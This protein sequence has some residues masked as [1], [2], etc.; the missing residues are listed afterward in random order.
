MTAANLGLSQVTFTAHGIDSLVRVLT[1]SA[2]CSRDFGFKSCATDRTLL[3]GCGDLPHY[4]QE[5]SIKS[6]LYHAISIP[7]LVF[8]N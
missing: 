5:N 3:G 7:F 4:L 6:V 8:Y 2:L 1:I